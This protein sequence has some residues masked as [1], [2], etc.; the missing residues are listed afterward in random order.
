VDASCA[1]TVG[2][3]AANHPSNKAVTQ[4]RNQTLRMIGHFLGGPAMTSSRAESARGTDRL[5]VVGRCL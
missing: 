2:L 3:A 5:E 4:A 1:V